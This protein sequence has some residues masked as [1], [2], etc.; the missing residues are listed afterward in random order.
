MMPRERLAGWKIRVP[1]LLGLG[2]SEPSTGS[3]YM[4]HNSASGQWRSVGELW[5]P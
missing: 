4:T 3:F 5:G 2:S 1:L